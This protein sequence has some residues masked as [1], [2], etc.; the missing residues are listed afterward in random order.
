MSLS[1]LNPHIAQHLEQL[2]LFALSSHIDEV[3]TEDGTDASDQAQDRRSD[4]S[5]NLSED[6]NAAST[7]RESV[8]NHDPDLL[9]EGNS[10]GA[11]LIFENVPDWDSMLSVTRAICQSDQPDQVLLDLQERQYP[12]GLNDERGD[13]GT[14]VQLISEESSEFEGLDE[15][16]NYMDNQMTQTSFDGVHQKFLPRN[17]FERA[18]TVGT[19][20]RMLSAPPFD[21]LGP[22]YL[23]ELA[24]RIHSRSRRTF[25][26]LVQ[27]R[28]PLESMHDV[29]KRVDLVDAQLPHGKG[30]LG[31]SYFLIDSLTKLGQ[32]DLVSRFMESQKYF[33]VAFFATGSFQKLVSGWIIPIDF[34]SNTPEQPELEP[35]GNVYKVL[36]H[37]QQHNFIQVY[38]DTITMRVYDQERYNED[39][40]LSVLGCRSPHLA[41]IFAAFTFNAKL[42]VL[43]QLDFHW[44]TLDEFMK[45]NKIGFHETQLLTQ[46]SG[47]TNALQELQNRHQS[48]PLVFGVTPARIHVPSSITPWLYL[49]ADLD[50]FVDREHWDSI[51]GRYMAPET[52]VQTLNNNATPRECMWSL[53]CTFLEILIWQVA[54]YARLEEFREALG[55]NNGPSSAF[56]RLSRRRPSEGPQIHPAVVTMFEHM[57]QESRGCIREAVLLVQ[58]MIQIDPDQRPSTTDVYSEFARL[59]KMDD[60]PNETA[61]DYEALG[62][63]EQEGFQDIYSPPE[64]SGSD[65]EVDASNRNNLW[66]WDGAKIWNGAKIESSFQRLYKRQ[67]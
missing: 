6:S 12:Q 66:D 2:S 64:D 44:L 54:G 27:I 47:I 35:N 53:G 24:R 42:Y 25:A 60:E 49:S 26:S 61:L 50:D 40:V 57:L 23:S 16:A 55:W 34:D 51:C 38:D 5:E 7:S 48:Q 9:D 30:P 39:A 1:K 11:Q 56:Y 62:S 28:F 67:V 32:E 52:S 8:G 29:L 41:E 22:E 45:A 58:T 14:E 43:Q 17:A 4:D 36:V 63:E 65:W 31:K 37:A 19:I 15:L 33:N 3:S 59:I 21:R 18:T 13:A 20:Q 46:L 10:E